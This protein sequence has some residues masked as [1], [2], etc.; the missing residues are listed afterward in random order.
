MRLF[1]LLILSAFFCVPTLG[2]AQQ[3]YGEFNA[4]L[5]DVTA[6]SPNLTNNKKYQLHYSGTFLNV[7]EGTKVSVIFRRA[8]S[9]R[10]IIPHFALTDKRG[11][12]GGKSGVMSKKFMADDYEVVFRFVMA[13]QSRQIRKWFRLNMGWSAKHIEILDVVEFT[14]GNL[15]QKNSDQKQFFKTLKGFH[16]RA[17]KVFSVLDANIKTGLKPP[18]NWKQF[19]YVNLNA[20][21]LKLQRDFYTWE[22]SYVDLPHGKI[23]G[24]LR[25]LI[26]SLFTVLEDYSNGVLQAIL[27]QHTTRI[28]SAMSD[29]KNQI[30]LSPI[31]LTPKSNGA[32]QKGAA[33]GAAKT[34]APAESTKRTVREAKKGTSKQ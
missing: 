25:N 15:D 28:R 10:F 7:P 5:R 17:D 34:P 6:Q 13:A 1:Q 16:S 19:G 26:N 8:N 14:L 27:N 30:S 31:P 32:K 12:F 23:Y 11:K 29:L 33:K 21:L 9:Q 2:C 18:V 24:R 22:C 3:S 20:T 4:E